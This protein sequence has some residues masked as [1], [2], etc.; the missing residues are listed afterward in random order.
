MDIK[1]TRE[2]EDQIMFSKKRTIGQQML[3]ILLSL[4]MVLTMAGVPSGQVEAADA[5]ESTSI[6]RF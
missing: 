3:A 4:V 6:A 2:K 1:K 5:N